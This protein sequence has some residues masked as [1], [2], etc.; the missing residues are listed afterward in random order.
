L[1]GLPGIYGALIVQVNRLD[2][3]GSLEVAT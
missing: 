3:V 2:I 1:K